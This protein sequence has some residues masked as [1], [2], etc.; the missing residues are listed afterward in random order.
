MIDRDDDAYE[1][2]LDATTPYAALPAISCRLAQ[3]AIRETRGT[4]EAD[5]DLSPARLDE[6]MTRLIPVIEQRT[7]AAIE[8]GWQ[9]LQIERHGVQ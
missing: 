4:L 9:R 6:I 3:W 7:I 2:V 5:R 1:P 8:S